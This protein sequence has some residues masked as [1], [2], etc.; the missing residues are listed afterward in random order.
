M[1]GVICNTNKRLKLNVLRIDGS[2]IFQNR[3]WLW[4]MCDSDYLLMIDTD[5]SFPINSVDIIMKS[6]ETS[7]A[8][9]ISGIY[10]HG[11]EPYNIPAIYKFSK[12]YDIFEPIK[13]RPL[14]TCEID[15]CGMGFC[16]I[17]KKKIGI[18]LGNDPFD[19]LNI[20]GTKLGEDLSFCKRAKD[21]GFHIFCEPKINLGHIRLKLI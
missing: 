13:D 6:I 19:L 21:K 1:I 15:G 20:N 11:Y 12:N 4:N 14:E 9:I 10:N 3:N 16:L 2:L 18:K 17:N 8:D 7:G 5:M